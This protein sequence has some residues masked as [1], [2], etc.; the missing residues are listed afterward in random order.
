MA[1]SLFYAVPAKRKAIES[2]DKSERVRTGYFEKWDR[3]T[4]ISKH[5]WM[6][7]DCILHKYRDDWDGTAEELYIH[8]VEHEQ[9]GHRVH[10]ETFTTLEEEIIETNKSTARSHIMGGQTRAKDED[11]SSEGC[12]VEVLGKGSWVPRW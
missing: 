3:V 2:A 12:Y 11:E 9:T 10:E 1:E 5:H 8:L 6:C 7:Y 4:G